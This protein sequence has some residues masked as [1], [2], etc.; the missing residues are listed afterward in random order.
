MIEMIEKGSA[1][2][3]RV[4]V[5]A[6]AESFVLSIK[7]EGTPVLNSVTSTSKT[8]RSK[9][10]K[11]GSLPIEPSAPNKVTLKAQAA[12]NYSRSVLS[13]LL[14]VRARVAKGVRPLLIQDAPVSVNLR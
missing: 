6:K 5:F 7:T 8:R 3:D 1:I 11:L 12:D 10:V 14:I 4:K 2:L 9:L 13:H